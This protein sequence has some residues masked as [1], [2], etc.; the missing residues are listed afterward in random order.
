MVLDI[1][2][3]GESR[4]DLA[5]LGEILLRFCPADG[6]IRTA[7]SFDVF[8]GGGE[9]NVAKNL[10]SC[11]HL[12]TAV[13]TA[14]ADNEF[15]RLAEHLA[16]AGGVDVSE[17][18]WRA[19]DGTRNG[20]YFIERGFGLRAPAS[21]FDRKDTAVSNLKPGEF[22]WER[23]CRSARWLHTGGIFAGLGESTPGVAL[24]AM[25]TARSAGAV[26]SFDLNYRDSIWREK[27]GREAANR[28]NRE[29]L[30]HADVVFGLFDFDAR[31]SRYDEAEFRR[32]AEA[33]KKDFPR[34]RIIVSSLRDVATAGRHDLSVALWCEGEVFKARDYTNCEVFD[35]VGSGDAIAAGVIYGFLQGETPQFAADCGAA[36]GVLAMTTAGDNLKV[37]KTEV[38]DLMR[39]AGAAVKR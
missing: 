22:D 4:R 8:D 20:L 38:E 28:L 27:G 32:K 6:R 14:L 7:R 24:E 13:V 31:L 9:Y 18:L 15:G 1:K 12:K 2:T 10:A 29:L 34:L 17:I 36:C 33:V 39:G 23:I 30:E 19:A 25:Q 21:C 16:R 11:F 3:A 35:R 26:V 37:S 5:S